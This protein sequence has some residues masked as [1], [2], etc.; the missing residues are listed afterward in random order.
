M[1]GQS[2]IS[3]QA[4]TP[5]DDSAHNALG[6]STKTRPARPPR[7]ISAPVCPAGDDQADTP[8][9][10]LGQGEHQRAITPGDV[11]PSVFSLE[12]AADLL[13]LKP[14]TLKQYA[15]GGRIAY[16]SPGK[17]MLFMLADLMAFINRNRRDARS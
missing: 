17:R 13:G 1:A 15:Y 9:V 10:L 7:D 12:A 8:L 2:D 5:G 11:L 16:C 4:L 6:T 3:T 14:S